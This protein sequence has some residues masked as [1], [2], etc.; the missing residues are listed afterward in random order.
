MAVAYGKQTEVKY[1][2]F[3]MLILIMSS[4]IMSNVIMAN[5]TYDKFNLWQVL[6]TETILWE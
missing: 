2:K 3:V 5:V 6:L 1:W 4:V